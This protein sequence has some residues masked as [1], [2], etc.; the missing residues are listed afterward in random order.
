MAAADIFTVSLGFCKEV[1]KITDIKNL[2]F[3]KN[4]KYEILFKQ[5]IQWFTCNF[6][7]QKTYPF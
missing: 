2:D 6:R 3:V 7:L 1:R 4:I 5:Q